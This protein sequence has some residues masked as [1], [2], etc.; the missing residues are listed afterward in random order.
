D[1]TG[2]ISSTGKE[3]DGIWAQSVGGGGVSGGFSIA[4]DLTVS[5]PAGV[6]ASVGGVGGHGGNADTVTIKSNVGTTL[7]APTVATISTAGAGS[8]GIFAQSVGGGG[9][10][11]G[12]SGRLTGPRP[13][14]EGRMP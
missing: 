6:A 2:R 11:G 12:F 9:G 5:G 7:P 4:G 8:V 14:S 1:R 13:H 3:S 10:A